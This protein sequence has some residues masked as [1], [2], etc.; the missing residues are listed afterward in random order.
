MKRANERWA[1]VIGGDVQASY[2][3]LSAGSKATTSYEAYQRKARLKGF[4]QAT[5]ESAACTGDIC[6]VKV[7]LVLDTVKMKG[8]QVPETE[9]WIL[10]KGDYWYVFPF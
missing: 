1:A 7:Q 4:R 2:A 3:M 6:R 8:I 9:T 10:E 5:V